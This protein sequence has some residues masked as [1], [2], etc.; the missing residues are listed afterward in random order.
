MTK[1]DKTAIAALLY[2]TMRRTANRVID[3]EW[4]GKNEEYARE[5]IHL[6]RQQGAADL[7]RY[8]E[9]YEELA[10][11]K[12][13]ADVSALAKHMVAERLPT[14]PESGAEGSSDPEDDGGG[15]PGRY[16]GTLR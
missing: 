12:P 3:V 7:S 13:V 16:I 8:A 5:I 11:G 4:L 6:A 9:R 15:S 1:S 2:V 14:P 10:F